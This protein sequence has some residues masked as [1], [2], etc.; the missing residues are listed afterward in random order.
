ML[1]IF[2]RY[3]F[4]L[5]LFFVGFRFCHLEKNSSLS[6]NEIF[7]NKVHGGTL[8]RWNKMPDFLLKMHSA[9]IISKL[10]LLLLS[11]YCYLYVILTIPY[12]HAINLSYFYMKLK[13]IE[14]DNKKHENESK[15]TFYFTLIQHNIEKSIYLLFAVYLFE[16]F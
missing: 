8:F 7:T 6:T 1:N 2:V 4:R 9:R 10:Q 12:F 11:V 13:K 15:W 3:K 14:Q 5:V 16:Y